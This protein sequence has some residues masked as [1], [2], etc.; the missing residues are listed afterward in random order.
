M[1]NKSKT[2]LVLALVLGAA[3]GATAATKHPVHHQR[4]AVE[5]QRSG[6]NAYGYAGSAS[7]GNTDPVFLDAL[8][9]QAAG[10]P[11]CWGGN[12]DPNWSSS[13]DAGN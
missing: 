5:R 3:S 9:R 10:D 11:R 4:S 1:L 8:R 2:A 13:G 6:A 7:S 12:C